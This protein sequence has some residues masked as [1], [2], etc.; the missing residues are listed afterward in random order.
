MEELR[1]G[2]GLGG[3]SVRGL[4]RFRL[5]FVFRDL[6]PCLIFVVF[7]LSVIVASDMIRN[8]GEEIAVGGLR[9]CRLMFAIGSFRG[10]R[11]L[12][13]IVL[14][15]LPLLHL[16]NLGLSEQLGIVEGCFRLGLQLDGGGGGGDEGD[17]RELHG[18]LQSFLFYCL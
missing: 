13:L 9:G 1:F 14:L 3:G 11:V 16:L 6:L 7:S 15:A 2:A 17:D 12:R 10:F 4:P 5:S 8:A 18:W